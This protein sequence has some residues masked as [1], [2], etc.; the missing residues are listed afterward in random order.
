MKKNKFY[1]IIT[2]V[3]TEAVAPTA[4]N[5]AG[6]QATYNPDARVINVVAS[7]VP[8]AISKVQLNP[9]E[10]IESV[11]RHNFIDVI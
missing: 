10:H 1:Q 9:G 2:G 6:T 4:D 8:E 5:P 7:D 11:A 3:I